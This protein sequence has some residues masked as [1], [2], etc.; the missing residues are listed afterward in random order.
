MA[1]S[2]FQ[3][4][5]YFGGNHSQPSALAVVEMADPVGEKPV[6]CHHAIRLF[7]LWIYGSL[8]KGI[9]TP[10]ISTPSKTRHVSLIFHEM[11]A[12]ISAA[13]SALH[14]LHQNLARLTAIITAL[15]HQMLSSQNP[16]AS[17]H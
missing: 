3:L 6:C 9:R 7:A 10:S 5:P 12:E 14:Q 16:T 1:N 13:S 4:F 2:F 11:L 17:F 8:F 15:T